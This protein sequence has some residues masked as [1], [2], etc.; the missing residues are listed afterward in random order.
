MEKENL[1][2][3]F[4][5]SLDEFSQSPDPQVWERIQASLDQ[6]ARRR[7][8]VVPLWWQLGGAAAALALLLFL[9]IPGD[10]AETVPQTN[11]I[12]NTPVRNTPEE[13]PSK[14]S[15]SVFETSKNPVDS[16]SAT[17]I[18]EFDRNTGQNQQDITPNKASTAVASQENAPQETFISESVNPVASRETL[19]NPSD[20]ADANAA[21]S[22]EIS[23]ANKTKIAEAVTSETETNTANP[24]EAEIVQ[25]EELAQL[26]QKKAMDEL[27]S[28]EQ[29]EPLLE[30]DKAEGKWA[31]GPSVAPVYFNGLGDGS[32]IDQAF[33]S[34][35]KTGSFNM[36]YGLQVSYQLN[37]RLQIRSG[38]HKVDYG[39]NTNDIV[40]SSS[41]QAS[42][43][44]QMKNVD[45]SASS[46]Y[47]VVSSQSLVPTKEVSSIR[48][49]IA[50]R[51]TAR[52]GTMVQ[53][54]GYLEVPFELNYALIDRTLGVHLISGISS[55]FL[56][57]NMVS[58]ESGTG[59]T[60]VGQ[61]N[62]LNEVNFSANFGLGVQYKVNDKIKLQ[63]EPLLKYQLNTFS[64]TAGD[65][66][67]Y[68]IGI[69][70]GIRYKF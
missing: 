4:R 55:L 40:F 14:N 53:E 64:E 6:K 20:P 21:G 49:E 46:E 43:A 34:N 37:K 50:A 48:N 32:P 33:V 3:L 57:D 7:R 38:L 10:Q 45:Y 30:Q 25:S 28:G 26:K 61:A 23:Q 60:E 9:L 68:S 16:E 12:S 56:V 44:A 52:E 13:D 67:P 5:E 31:I 19:V 51:N 41:L 8:R 47:L 2:N 58:L 35:K 65:F 59:T 24:S 15:E 39:Y 62:N 70:S 63:V 36:S 1:D 27:L 54:F 17:E 11:P 69:Y 42:S 18:V 22:D 66:R 29:E